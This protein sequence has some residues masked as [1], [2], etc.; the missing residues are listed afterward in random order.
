MKKKI[1]YGAIVVL[2]ISLAAVTASNAY[3]SDKDD[4]TND[5]AFGEV[6]A[7]IKE[8]LWD[9]KNIIIDTENQTYTETEPKDPEND[10]F[11]INNN[12][13]ISGKIIPK[14]PRIYNIGTEPGYI[15]A[16]VTINNRNDLHKIVETIHGDKLAAQT[17]ID[18]HLSTITPF[19]DTF[20]EDATYDIFYRTYLLTGGMLDLLCDDITKYAEPAETND[21]HG[22]LISELRDTEKYT[23]A[24]ANLDYNGGQTHTGIMYTSTSDET[25]KIFVAYSENNQN[26]TITLTFFLYKIIPSGGQT[27]NLFDKVNVPYYFTT[28]DTQALGGNARVSRYQ[29]AEDAEDPATYYE[30]TALER[31]GNAEEDPALSITISAKIIQSEGMGN[32]E[33]AF[34]L[35]GY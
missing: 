13:L 2:L 14:D 8:P 35:L 27:M 22:I 7:I 3:F 21:V 16:E 20:Y 11:G 26:D 4:S 23:A 18:G 33:T 34:D 29:Y 10:D 12:E 25:D 24:E 31:T 6:K 9:G 19:V 32:A 17:M 1:I 30:A 15:V 5:F 28:E